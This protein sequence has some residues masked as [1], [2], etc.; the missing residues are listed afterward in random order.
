[1]IIRVY[2]GFS[3]YLN[4]DLKKYK[5]SHDYISLMKVTLKLDDKLMILSIIFLT[6]SLIS[7]G[8]LDGDFIPGYFDSILVI[9]FTGYLI[10]FSLFLYYN[11]KLEKEKIMEKKGLFDID[12][13]YQISFLIGLLIFVI[14]LYGT[15]LDFNIFLTAFTPAGLFAMIYSVIGWHDTK[16]KTTD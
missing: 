4:I 15:L 9:F 6:L 1:M 2:T 11:H 13:P 16:S 5:S 7:I 10:T 14:G 12:K 3:K 8:L